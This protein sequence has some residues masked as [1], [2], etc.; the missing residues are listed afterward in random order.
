MLTAAEKAERE[1]LATLSAIK[2][3]VMQ[4]F[5]TEQGVSHGLGLKPEKV[6]ADVK[7]LLEQGYLERMHMSSKLFV[8]YKGW[9]LDK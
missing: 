9:R 6:T 4:K 2:T 8:T 1:A 3:Y 7:I 5:F